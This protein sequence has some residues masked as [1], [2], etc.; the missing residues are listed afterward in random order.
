VKSGKPDLGGS[1]D[2]RSQR[3]DKIK[4]N[5]NKMKAKKFKGLKRSNGGTAA[6]TAALADVTAQLDATNDVLKEK[7]A[8]KT[9]ETTATQEATHENVPVDFNTEEPDELPPDIFITRVNVSGPSWLLW[10]FFFIFLE[11]FIESII[12]HLCL[13]VL[14]FF[15]SFLKPHHVDIRACTTYVRD[16]VDD[17]GVGDRGRAVVCGKI[18]KLDYYMDLCFPT[19]QGIHRVC[20]KDNLASSLLYYL[21]IIFDA[22]LRTFLLDNGLSIKLANV[23]VDPMNAEIH[24][25][26]STSML[27]ELHSRKTIFSKDPQFVTLAQRM[28]MMPCN[29]AIMFELGV[30][31]GNC[32][33]K[34]SKLMHSGQSVQPF[35]HLR[36]VTPYNM[37]TGYTTQVSQQNTTQSSQASKCFSSLTSIPEQILVVLRWLVGV[38]FI[39]LAIAF[40][41]LTLVILYQLLLVAPSGLHS[42]P[43]QQVRS[44]TGEYEG[45]C[46]DLQSCLSDNFIPES[47]SNPSTVPQPSHSGSRTQ[48]TEVHESSSYGLNTTQVRSIVD[49]V[50]TAII[51][52]VL[53]TFASLVGWLM[54]WAVLTVKNWYLD[55]GKTRDKISIR[56]YLKVTAAITLLILGPSTILGTILCL[57]YLV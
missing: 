8:I 53:L 3:P 13:L 17:R 26:V 22:K 1:G 44:W 11:L 47:Y 6:L 21:V 50:A 31:V 42:H 29:Q 39:F 33:I 41:V 34:V 35:Q 14:A 10:V 45:A 7:D 30:S 15:W 18:Y 51:M 20:T 54:K 19:Q 5:G 40:I 43:P 25:I 57:Y 12:P 9:Q 48:S 28:D 23:L 24:D 36:P 38:G 27:R 37:D 2:G 4:I 32:T 56:F 55:D 49:K 52:Q 16:E 46:G